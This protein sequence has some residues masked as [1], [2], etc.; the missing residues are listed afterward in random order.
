MELA[1]AKLVVPYMLI[2]ALMTDRRQLVLAILEPAADLL[3]A[4]PELYLQLDK[5]DQL[6]GHS[7]SAAT[8]LFLALLGLLLGQVVIVSPAG[9][10][11][12]GIPA[13]L[14]PD[15]CP[16][17]PDITR[18]IGIRETLVR[19]HIDSNPVALAKPLISFH[20]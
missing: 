3:R 15:R 13:L 2:D 9:W 16:V 20:N 5:P 4:P 17:N 18:D 6:G 7:R 10:P 12:R 14:S 1:A 11:I 19:Q 8:S